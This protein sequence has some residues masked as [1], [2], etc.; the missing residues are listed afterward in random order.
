MFDM[1]NTTTYQLHILVNT[2]KLAFELHVQYI[3]PNSSK[4]HSDSCKQRCWSDKWQIN[5]RVLKRWSY[6][7]TN[8]SETRFWEV[9]AMRAK[10]GI[11]YHEV[12]SSIPPSNLLTLSVVDKGE[13]TI[14]IKH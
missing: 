5:A 12:A 8:T 7:K 9:I 11:S 14:Y 3:E 4:A 13:V 6:P 1:A 2:A 10:A